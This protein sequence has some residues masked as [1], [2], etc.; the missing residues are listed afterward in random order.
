[1]FLLRVI[2]VFVILID[3]YQPISHILQKLGVFGNFPPTVLSEQNLHN[4]NYNSTSCCLIW[5][6]RWI[7]FSNWRT[8]SLEQSASSD[9]L[10]NSLSNF[11]KAASQSLE[12]LCFLHWEQAQAL[13]DTEEKTPSQS[14]HFKLPKLV[15]NSE[16]SLHLNSCIITYLIETS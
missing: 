11:S 5:L 3:K 2:E 1:M 15:S 10:F 8:V 4:Y 12:S 13:S 7:T 16:P 6:S 14:K 9:W